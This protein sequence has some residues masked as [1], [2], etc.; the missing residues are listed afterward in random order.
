VI[1]DV[2]RVL[3]KTVH[4]AVDFSFILSVFWSGFITHPADIPNEVQSKRMRWSVSAASMG[5]RRTM[6]TGEP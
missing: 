6:H 5:S 1:S 3:E 4:C 2:K